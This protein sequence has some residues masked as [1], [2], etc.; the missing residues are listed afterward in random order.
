MWRQIN[1]RMQ[2]VKSQNT[3]MFKSLCEDEV[4][5]VHVALL[6]RYRQLCET[7]GGSLNEK[8]LLIVG[9]NHQH[10]ILAK[11]KTLVRIPNIKVAVRVL[12]SV[13]GHYCYRMQFLH[14]Y[15]C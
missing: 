5:S 3:V 1:T 4:T 15:N 10:Q 14:Y 7:R 2:G 12:A 9:P 6:Y 8:V 13:F 11:Q